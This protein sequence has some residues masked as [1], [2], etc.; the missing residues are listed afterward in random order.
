MPRGFI[1]DIGRH[2]PTWRR[3][4]IKTRSPRESGMRNTRFVL[5]PLVCAG[6]MFFAANVVRA[7]D[8][9]Q[10][11]TIKADHNL[12]EAIKKHGPQ[13]PEA[14]HWRQELAASRSFCWDHDK[15]WW[16]EDA[17]QWRTE[18]SWDDHDHEH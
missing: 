12:H 15:R 8:D 16:D 17:H 7:D 5:T 3:K 11:R 13:S 6:A 18:H 4:K 14:E 9:C 1:L 10:K 2:F